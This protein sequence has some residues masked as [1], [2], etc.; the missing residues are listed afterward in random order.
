L[1]VNVGATPISRFGDTTMFG[2]KM[3]NYFCKRI[4]RGASEVAEKAKSAYFLK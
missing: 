3:R 2:Q 1:K 4:L